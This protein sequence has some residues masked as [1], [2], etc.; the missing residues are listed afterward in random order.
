MTSNNDF[1]SSV[2]HKPKRMYCHECKDYTQSIEP[3]L[4]RRYNKQTFS[5]LAKCEKCNE[6]KNIALSDDFYKK[7]PL[8]YFD[9]K[10]SKFFLNEI[11]DNYNIKHKI[12][13]DLFYLINEPLEG[14]DRF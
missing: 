6:I 4:N 12:E 7:F 14:R 3:I 11:T 8:Y 9:L 13:K 5:I 1:G 10:L 2:C